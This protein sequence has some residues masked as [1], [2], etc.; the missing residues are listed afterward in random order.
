MKEWMLQPLLDPVILNQRYDG[1]DL[2]LHPECCNGGVSNGTNVGVL[3]NLM[4]RVG[5]V[6]KI[7][8]RMQ[9]CV[10]SPQDFLVLLRTLSAA[11]TLCATLGKDIRDKML[12]IDTDKNEEERRMCEDRET[13]ADA[14]GEQGGSCDCSTFGGR[15]GSG[16]NTASTRTKH[17][18]AFL[19]DI[20]EQCSTPT[21]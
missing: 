10:A 19:D 15:G 17:C 4:S 3:L 18:V 12:K 20:L 11:V 6:D 9:K 7:L 16:C 8:L 14:Q 13:T 5:A 2:F 21:L 1:I